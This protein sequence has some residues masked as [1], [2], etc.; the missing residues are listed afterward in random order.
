ME[1]SIWNKDESRK[2]NKPTYDAGSFGNLEF[3]GNNLFSF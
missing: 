3:C 2:K 1:V